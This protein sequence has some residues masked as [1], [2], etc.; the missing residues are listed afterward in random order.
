MRRSTTFF[1]KMKI[2]IFVLI[3]S[4]FACNTLLAQQTKISDYVIFGGTNGQAGKTAPAA[5]GYGVTIGSPST[6]Q[7]GSIGSY[8]FIRSTG[9]VTFG[10]A[11]NQTNI[12]SGGTIALAG[13]NIVRGNI[14]ASNSL[15]RSGTILSVGANANLG[16]N[17]DVNGNIIITNGVVSG[18]VTNPIGSTYQLGGITIANIKGTPSL[19]LLPSIAISN[20]PNAGTENITSTTNKSPGAY[21]NLSL[22]GNNTLTLSGPG[23]YVFSSI[24]TSGPNSNIVFDFKNTTS[25]NFLMYVYG[26]IK[27]N[28]TTFSMINGGSASRIYTETHGTGSTNAD[29]RTAAFFMSNGS[30]GSGNQSGWLGAVWAPY[31][32]IRVGSPNGPS[33]SVNGALWSG[34]QV[35]IQSGVNFTYA[36][37][38]GCNLTGSTTQTNVLCKGDA[39]GAINVTVAGGVSPYTYAWTGPTG[40]VSTNSA[41]ISRLKAGIY[42]VTI[43]DA[44][45]CTGNTAA[46]NITEP[47]VALSSSTTQV[48]ILCNGA[49]TGSVKVLPI[50]GTVPYSFLWSNGATIED[51]SGLATG[52]YNV[53]V[54]DKNGCT[55]TA[56]ATITQSSSINISSILSNGP[57]CAGTNLNLTTAADGGTGTLSYSWSGPNGFTSSLQNPIIPATTTATSGRYI[58][59][60]T[61]INGCSKSNSIDVIVNANP[62]ANAGVDKTLQFT[63][64]STL[65]GTSSTVGNLNYNWQAGN[66]GVFDPPGTPTNTN[67]IGVSSAGIYTLTVANVSTGC[68]TTDNVEVTSKLNKIIGS[69]LQSIFENKTTDNSIFDIEDG[70]IKIDIIVLDIPGKRTAVINQLYETTGRPDFKGLKDSLPNGFS[71]LTI[72]GRYPIDSLPELNN[73]GNMVNYI[74]PYYRPILFSASNVTIGGDTSEVGIR[75]AGDTAIRSHLVRGGYEIYGKDIKVGV[76]SDSYANVTNGTSAVAPFNPVLTTPYTNSPVGTVNPLVQ[77]F[78]TNTFDQDIANGD[79]PGAANPFGYL[80]NINVLLDQPAKGTDEGRAMLQIVHDVAPAAELYFR[81]GFFTAGDFAKGIKELKDAGCDIIVDDLTYITEPFLK[82]GIVA[83][84]VNEQVLDKKMTYFSAAGN[85]GNKSYERNFNPKVITTGILAGQTAHDFGGGDIYQKVRLAAGNYTFVFQWVDNIYSLDET[86]GTINDL[87]IYLTKNTDGTGLVGFNRNNLIGDPIEFIPTT[88]PGIPGVDSVDYNILIINNNPGN[89]APRMKYIVFRGGIRFMEGFAGEGA[90]TLV[91]QANAAGAIAVGAARYNYVKNY[92]NK[93]PAGYP[94]AVPNNPLIPSSILSKPQIETFSSIGGTFTNGESTPRNKPELVGPDGGNTTVKLGQDYPDWALDGYS[95]FFG[96]SAAAPHIAGAAALLMEG[97]KKYLGVAS[98]S[99]DEM[100]SLLQSTA[101]DMATTGFDYISGKGF[102]DVDSA[103]RSFASPR[104]RSIKLVIPSSS[105]LTIPGNQPFLLKVTGENFS[106]NSEIWINDTKLTTLSIS[107]TMDTICATIPAFT[108]NPQIRVYTAPKTNYNDGGFSNS[109]NFFTA[110]IVIRAVDTTIKYGQQIPNQQSIKTII[111]I[112]GKLLKDTTVSLAD[113]G[114]NNNIQYIVTAGLN[115]KVGTYTILP[116]F[117]TL[118]EDALLRKYNYDFFKGDLNIQ[119]LPLKITPN[120][121]VVPYGQYIGDVSF[122]YDFDPAY[123]LANAQSLLDEVKTF[124]QSYLPNNALAV[125]NDFSKVQEDLTTLKFSDL[126]NLNMMVSLAALKNSRKFD[127]INNK[128]VPASDPN[129]YNIQYLLDLSSQSIFDYKNNSSKTK[130]ING[131]TGLSNKAILSLNSLASNT[132]NVL[133]NGSLVQMLNGSLVQMLNSDSDPRAPLVNGSLVQLLNGSLV[134]LLNGV[135]TPIA[136]GSLVQLLNGSLVQLLNGV[137]TPIPNGSLV[138]LLNGTTLTNGSLVQMLNGSLVQ[139]LNGQNIPI[140]NG[141]LVQMLNGSLVQILNGVPTAI[142]NGSLVQMLNGS[143][144]QILN[145]S[146][147]QLLN[148]SLVQL[149]NG[150]LVQLLNGSLVQLLNSNAAG[151]DNPSIKSAVIFDEADVTNKLVGSMFG[152]NMITGL[153]AGLQKLV[154]GVLINENF[155]ITYGLGNVDIQPENIT[156]TPN[157]GQK[158]IYGQVDPTIT[159]TANKALQAGETFSGLITR[160]EGE[161]VGTYAI[162]SGGLSIKNGVKDVSSNYN[163]IYNPANFAITKRPITITVT[164]GQ[165]KLNGDPDPIFAYTS[166]L[167]GSSPAQGLRSPDAFSGSLTRVDGENVGTYTILQSGLTIRNG[168]TDVS[169]NYTITYIGT[170]FVILTNPCLITHSSVSNFGSTANPRTPTSLW[171]SMTTKVSGQLVNDGDY[172][173]F[174]SGDIT[175]TNITSTPAVANFPLPAGKIVAKTG[176]LTPISSYDSVARIWTTFVPLG[177]SSTSDIFVTGA[178]INSTT[179]FVRKN[180]DRHVARGIFYSNV[181]FIDKWGYAMAAYQRPSTTYIYYKDVYQA[182]S[183]QSVNG[184]YK[185]GTALNILNWLVNGASGGGGNNYT[186]SSS[187]FD[188]FTACPPSTNSV[189]SR[190]IIS[191]S[192]LSAGRVVLKDVLLSKESMEVYPNPATNF[193]AL[194]F[195]PGATGSSEITLLTIDGKKVLGI[196]NG[197]CEAGRKYYKRMDIGSLAKGVYIIQ[198]RSADKITIKKVIINR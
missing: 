83:K 171:F 93:V 97:R 88:I 61:D 184:S 119:K 84:T 39:T 45:G 117:T 175:F 48:N 159:Y 150:S 38:S 116:N 33:M 181:N 63:G 158:K 99:P 134:Q 105:P 166:T 22:S 71:R 164:T 155:E 185:S 144:V 125:I 69:E 2:S 124:H 6:I 120:D 76:I 187:S 148:G 177:F 11:A 44:A 27:L 107:A 79:L 169:S 42:N 95:N 20:F 152:I 86:L 51:L 3:L 122:K 101:V 53:T 18:V 91:A 28:R 140:V 108:G 21:A 136:N 14:A 178:I 17:L 31:A 180:K 41:S 37:Y 60:V 182:G 29:D 26:D 115:S 35:N 128:L 137:A 32:A 139:L 50:G 80:K 160:A 89:P 195:V 151:S 106:V 25:G 77:K 168:I 153:N 54:T 149:L 87:D 188:N 179:G 90:S 43:T 19:P 156:I 98:T 8:Q 194:T 135:P 118:P 147:V 111:T 141:S 64:N 114:L 186:G 5:P 16:G 163:I 1:L 92:I 197:V 56:S 59:I 65:K 145:G 113:I 70:Y 49:L 189:I 104:P 183:V 132:G 102:V 62:N 30:N 142:P 68:F 129:N 109:L 100:K 75:S 46:V 81:T 162:N 191:P 146:L 170:T 40:F 176:T 126:A 74:R 94:V 196:D 73:L 82:D 192:P 15:G 36:R 10:T 67:V 112:N 7:G 167:S 12:Y 96:T 165:S 190:S 72:T 85:F 161:T 131:F 9:S 123:P 13:S 57:I 4:I 47:A 24:N 198:L 78:R 143:L 193:I 127:V 174:K 52:A 55:T 58:L 110:D 66:G 157:T 172:L 133:F 130:F 23:V 103:M 173:L 121:K 34:T 154:P 138:Q